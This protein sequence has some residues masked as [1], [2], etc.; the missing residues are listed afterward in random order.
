M[1][2]KNPPKYTS[3]FTEGKSLSL[4][5]ESSESILPCSRFLV[6]FYLPLMETDAVLYLF[7]LFVCFESLGWYFQHSFTAFLPPYGWISPLVGGVLPLPGKLQ[8]KWNV[9]TKQWKNKA[10]SC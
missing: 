8:L 5:T 9:L 2:K 4:E 1:M 3:T 7:D 6:M 10:E